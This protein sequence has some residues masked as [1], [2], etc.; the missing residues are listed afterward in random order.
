MYKSRLNGPRK[1]SRR[2]ERRPKRFQILTKRLLFCF[3]FFFF[4]FVDCF[5][6]HRFNTA[7]VA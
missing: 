3:S 5:T 1:M 4:F 6:L 2:L 7:S